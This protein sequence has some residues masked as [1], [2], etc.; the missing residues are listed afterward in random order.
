M[1]VRMCVCVGGGCTAVILHCSFKASQA[2]VPILSRRPPL[3]GLSP[4]LGRD[5]HRAAQSSTGT[6][7]LNSGLVKHR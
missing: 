7:L 6:H 1:C 4:P 3:H 5:R 2:I